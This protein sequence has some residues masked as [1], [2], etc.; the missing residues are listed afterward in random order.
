MLKRETSFAYDYMP[1]IPLT[2]KFQMEQP[3]NSATETTTHFYLDRIMS[4]KMGKNIRN[5]NIFKIKG[6]QVQAEPKD[7]GATD[8]FDTGGAL[9]GSIRYAPVTTHTVKAW[10]QGFYTWKKQQVMSSK[11][12]QH[13]KFNDFEVSYSASNSLDSRISELMDNPLNSATGDPHKIGLFGVSNDSS[14]YTSLFDLYN[15]RNP[16][17]QTPTTQYG[18]ALKGVKYSSFIDNNTSYSELPYTTINSAKVDGNG[19]LSNA[20]ADQTTVWLPRAESVLTGSMQIS[21]KWTP[22]DTTVQIEDDMY[23]NV[24]IWVQSFT[25]IIKSKGKRYARKSR[26]SRSRGYS[27]RFR[28]KSYAR[29]RRR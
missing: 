5:G 21:A 12:G 3:N 18:T 13:N 27:R 20:Q 11:F 7:T 4:Q 24:I 15:S 17:P 8:D 26:K 22:E 28:R 6:Y 2:F 10:K 19:A 23:I 29:R 1:L 25:S 16:I 14:N 9:Q